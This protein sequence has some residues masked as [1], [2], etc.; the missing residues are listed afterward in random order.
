[1]KNVSIPFKRGG[2]KKW[3]SKTKAYKTQYKIFSK[4]NMKVVNLYILCVNKHGS[5]I[6]S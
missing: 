3:K 6:K 5:E 4:L 2:T 1:M